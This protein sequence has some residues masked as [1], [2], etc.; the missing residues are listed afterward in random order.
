MFVQESE[1]FHSVTG[2][3]KFKSGINTFLIGT[4]FWKS[5]H[6]TTNPISKSANKYHKYAK[7]TL[8]NTVPVHYGMF[9]LILYFWPYFAS[10]KLFIPET[11]LSI[12][13]TDSFFRSFWFMIWQYFSLSCFI[14]VCNNILFSFY[15]ECLNAWLPFYYLYPAIHCYNHVFVCGF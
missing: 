15:L 5:C 11:L 14:K 6:F 9:H 13:L 2:N 1:K 3:E 12:F 10:L 8:R 7:I 4:Y